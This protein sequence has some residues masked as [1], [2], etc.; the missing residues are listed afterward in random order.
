MTPSFA[1]TTTINMTPAVAFEAMFNMARN[2]TVEVEDT[3]SAVAGL[4]A[5]LGLEGFAAT[6]QVDMGV[7]EGVITFS[8]GFDKLKVTVEDLKG[9]K[10]RFSYKVIQDFEQSL[11]ELRDFDITDFS[12]A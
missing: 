10:T 9:G 7:E 11:Q 8:K 5:I 2:K 3:A 6:V 1:I 12:G 4:Q